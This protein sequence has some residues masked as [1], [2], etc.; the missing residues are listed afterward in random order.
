[1]AL[2]SSGTQPGDPVPIA[3]RNVTLRIPLRRK[4]AD[5]TKLNPLSLLAKLYKPGKTR[6]E[7]RTIIE[8][9]SFEVH[10]GNRLALIG[11]NGAGKTTMLRLLAGSIS[12]SRGSIEIRGTTQALLNLSLGFR[13]AATGIENIYLR[14]L[15]MGMDLT[16]IKETIPDI[17]E[18]SELGDAIYDPIKTYSTGMRAKL[19]F[20]VATARKPNVLIMDEW[21]SAGDKYFVQ[22]AQKRLRAQVD[23]CRALVLASHSNS[24]LQE[25]CTH[26]MVMDA[27]RTLFFGKIDDALKFYDQLNPSAEPNVQ[28]DESKTTVTTE[29]S[30]TSTEAKDALAIQTSQ[31]RVL[32]TLSPELSPQRAARIKNLVKQGKFDDV[33][34]HH[35][36]GNFR[37]PTIKSERGS[38][39]K[40][41]PPSTASAENELLIC[42]EDGTLIDCNYKI[43]GRVVEGLE[44]TADKKAQASSVNAGKIS[45]K[46]TTSDTQ[47]G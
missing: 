20:S 36:V 24:I 39:D 8:G 5:S 11:R 9:A 12:P 13:P 35:A 23:T 34:L 47:V 41:Q 38:S 31:G 10:D 29:I 37:A 40:A 45:S 28:F 22:R 26:G 18:F 42:F 4:G 43:L 44:I 33:P 2:N 25:I 1:M 46:H 17:I 7:V 3:V 15:A 21:I 6:T 16:E 32:I 27:G 19:A 30:S 14:G